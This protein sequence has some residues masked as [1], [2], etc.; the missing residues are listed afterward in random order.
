M[1]PTVIDDAISSGYQDHV[2]SI[3]N[4]NFSWYFTPRISDDVSA[5]QKPDFHILYLR[6]Q[7]HIQII[8]ESLLPIFFELLNKYKRGL[9]Q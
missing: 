9:K 8:M 6:T 3:F 4:S 7:L 5:D 2:E 1:K